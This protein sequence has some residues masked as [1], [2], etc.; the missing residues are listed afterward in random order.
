MGSE[1]VNNLEGSEAA[2][3]RMKIILDTLSGE[4]SVDEACAKLGI[5]K[6]AFHELRKRVLQTAVN[7]LEPKAAGR[8]ANTPEEEKEL[9]RLRHENFE[10]KFA[11]RGT[12]LREELA[13]YF[14]TLV[15]RA[16][17]EKSK[18]KTSESQKSGSPPSP[19]PSKTLP[20]SSDEKKNTGNAPAEP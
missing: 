1:L 4:L 20:H 18:K 7:D 3:I 9:E 15:K 10:L 17:E 14:P 6:T 12:Q 8:P 11:I 5:K 13:L 16:R 2:K 19:S